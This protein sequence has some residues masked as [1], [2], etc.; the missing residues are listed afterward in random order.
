MGG[1]KMFS[2]DS[3]FDNQDSYPDPLSI[4]FISQVS[5]NTT[6][7]EVQMADILTMFLSPFNLDLT[8]EYNDIWG[9][10]DYTPHTLYVSDRASFEEDL[11]GMLIR[12]A[13]SNRVYMISSMDHYITILN[14]GMESLILLKSNLSRKAIASDGNE[15]TFFRGDM[16]ALYV[17]GDFEIMTLEV[18]DGPVERGFFVYTDI[19]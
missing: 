3:F 19:I 6:F 2:Y 4:P 7:E 1:Y 10:E 18:L 5:A 9:Y 14:K 13:L 15:Y 11:D 17:Y 8:I 12:Y 16:I